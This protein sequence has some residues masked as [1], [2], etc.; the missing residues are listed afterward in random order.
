[1]ATNFWQQLNKPII[2]LAPMAGITDSAFRLVCREYGADVVYSEMVSADGLHYNSQKTLELL[3]FSKKEKPLVVQLFGK[4][5]ES[6]VKATQA[7]TKAGVDGIDINFGCPAKKVFGHGS[8]AAL[9]NDLDTACEIIKTVLDNTDLPVSVKCRASVKG[10][11]ALDFVKKIKDLPVQ[12]IMVHG[13]SYEQKFSG[14]VDY[15]MIKQVKKVFK[16]IVLANGGIKKPKDA[17][18]M[19]EKTG[20]DG[21]GLAQGILGKPWLFQQIK[22]YL[23]IGDYQELDFSE[24]KKIA[25][26]HAKLMYKSKP[27]QGKFELR[28]H[29]A[30][31]VKG[32]AKASELRKKLVETSNL[33]EIKEIL[34]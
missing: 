16:G 23:K 6:F 20:A 19:L 27:D 28:K 12:A 5:P 29:L 10:V 14:S 18:V 2:A 30:W 22:D 25:L 34:K 3:N 15:E 8:G 33:E 9:M 24:I 31:Y 7:V 32:E 17:G 21:I 11:T 1:M 26:K 13:R 4:H